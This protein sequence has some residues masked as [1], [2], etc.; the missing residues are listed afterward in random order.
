ME[1]DPR[2]HAPPRVAGMDE[3]G[4]ATPGVGPRHLDD[5]WEDLVQG[6]SPAA[7]RVAG[8]I[9]AADGGSEGPSGGNARTFILK[10]VHDERIGGIEDR[11][12]GKD[13]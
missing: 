4:G 10:R 13:G 1:A 12:R 5:P 6:R 9:E 11:L 3:E 7:I 2:G 8:T